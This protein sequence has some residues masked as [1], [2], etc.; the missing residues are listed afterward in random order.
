MKFT[1]SL[2]AAASLCVALASCSAPGSNGAGSNP[3]AGTPRS[4]S[5]LPIPAR[6]SPAIPAPPPSMKQP[7]SPP[8]GGRRIMEDTP[9][10]AFFS[11]ETAV[12]G[13]VYY[14]AFPNSNVF[15]YYSY[16]SGGNYIYH[17][18]LGWE[19]YE[20]AN[21]SNHGIYLYDFSSG[22]W[23]Y[24]SPQ[25]PFPYLYDFT[26]D[27]T[28]YYYPDTARTGHYTTNPRYF[29]DF[30]TNAIISMPGP[31]SPTPR[32]TVPPGGCHACP[33]VGQ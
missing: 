30:G 26:L 8:A 29:Y 5:N 14:L 25:Y 19:Y 1:A 27:A 11:G 28:L 4:V 31:G 20:D 3:A 9:H 33:P 18:D 6:I 2:A 7:A 23:W 17:Y 21:D 15:G 16:D 12:G 32:P 13:G 24:T 22:D 10:P